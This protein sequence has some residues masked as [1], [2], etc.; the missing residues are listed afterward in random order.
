[1]FTDPSGLV[2]PTSGS[3]N[4]LD[5]PSLNITPFAPALDSTG[6]Q[7][8][9]E[10]N[11]G[12]DGITDDGYIFEGYDDS[13]RQIF[14]GKFNRCFVYGENGEKIPVPCPGGLQMGPADPFE[15]LENLLSDFFMGPEPLP[16]VPMV[17]PGVPEVQG[18]MPP[19]GPI[20]AIGAPSRGKAVEAAIED[21][22]IS[23]RRI[24]NKVQS[25]HIASDKDQF[26]G[27][28]FQELFEEAGVDMQGPWNLT[29]VPNHVGPHGKFYN[30][31]IYE[32]LL[33]AVNGKSGD[34]YKAA[35][36]DELYD[37]RREIQNGDLGDLLRAAA[38]G[39]D[40]KGNF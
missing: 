38:S 23:L 15:V 6:E 3:T 21:G 4:E 20:G 22:I 32:R 16:A 2:P 28:L 5:I 18:M 25:H 24:R 37:I 30:K 29:R 11:V 33:E 13:G 14:R 19:V 12:D 36:L 17:V 27:P 8:P 26:Y 39:D 7:A 34:S 35:L 31:H 10:V 1:M 40:V 9:D